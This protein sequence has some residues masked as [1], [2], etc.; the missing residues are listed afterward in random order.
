MRKLAIVQARM[1]STRLPGKVL[2]RIKG[3]PLLAYQLERVLRSRLIDRIVVATTW[4]PIDNAVVSLCHS[5]GIAVYRGSETDVLDRYEQTAQT[6]Q[7]DV[8]IRLTGDCP[9]IDPEVID[10]IVQHFLDNY[11]RFDYVSNTIKR[12]YPR[13]MDTEVFKRE[14]L[15][16]AHQEARGN[17]ERE[18]VTPYIYRHPEL[19]QIANVTCEHDISH[20]RWTVDTGK[21]L[22]LICRILESLYYEKPDFS[23]QHILALLERHPDWMKLNQ[24]VEQKPLHEC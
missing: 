3:K 20:H 10:L 12:S 4:H 19:F 13:G 16:R 2:E 17:E 14:A 22:Q 23:L 21:D 24:D 6:Y 15:R 18:H 7:A 11:S 1:N 9:L 8:I 5:M